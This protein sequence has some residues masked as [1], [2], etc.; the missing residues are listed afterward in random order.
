M[1]VLRILAALIALVAGLCGCTTS[2][3]VLAWEAG[4]K[5]E[6]AGDLKLAG[7]RYAEAYERNDRLVGAECNRLRLLARAPDKRAEVQEDLATLFKG[8]G[9]EPEVAIF[10]AIWALSMG[11]PKL[12]ATRLDAV[13]AAMKAKEGCPPLRGDF[14]RADLQVE[15][16]QAHWARARG[17]VETLTAQC[18]A[19]AV[20]A[21]MAA[22]VAWNTGDRDAAGTWLKG[23]P[24]GRGILPALLALHRGQNKRAV[25]LLAAVDQ[26]DMAH[27]VVLLQAHAA[28]ATGDIAS[29]E[30]LARRAL[31]A[32]PSSTA[33][34]QL[35]GVALLH[36]GDVQRARDLLAGAAA[37][38]KGTPPWT[39]SFDIAVAELRLGRL[40]KARAGFAA[41]GRA[42][43]K[44]PCEVA[45][46]NHAAM[47]KLGL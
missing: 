44:G 30:R 18:G 26:P 33:P 12:A 27:L 6:A 39:L 28:L 11:D 1:N 37:G 9:D 2:R 20:P 22:L 7:R 34:Q 10:G 40:D 29:A 16:A 43:E 17:R 32:Q 15:V 42:C 24:H 46:R 5:A 31:D 35:L 4:W 13:R 8:S 45:R 14:L 41:A 25:A 19:K 38:T 21:A 36:R 3:A 47:V 23:L